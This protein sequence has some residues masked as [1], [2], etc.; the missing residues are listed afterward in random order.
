MTLGVQKNN[1]G[2]GLQ[3]R[4]PGRILQSHNPGIGGVQSQ[5]YRIEKLSMIK[6]L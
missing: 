6:C 3:S 4:D 2:Y 1:S 5:H